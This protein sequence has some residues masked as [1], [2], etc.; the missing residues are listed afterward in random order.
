MLIHS[1]R[2]KGANVGIK[3]TPLLSSPLKCFSMPGSP[4][5]TGLTRYWLPSKHPRGF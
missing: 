5:Q 4:F 3:L 2:G 1:L